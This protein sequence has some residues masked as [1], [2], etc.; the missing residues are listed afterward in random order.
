MA[1]DEGS[2]ETEGDS[3]RYGFFD[4]FQPYR[5]VFLSAGVLLVIKVINNYFFYEYYESDSNQFKW[6]L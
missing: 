4:V 5:T 1:V 2:F 6:R 3:A